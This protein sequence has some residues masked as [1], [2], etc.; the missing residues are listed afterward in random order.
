MATV[1]E[2]EVNLGQTVDDRVSQLL[3]Y[4]EYTV[5]LPDG[6]VLSQDRPK[7]TQMKY[8]RLS[9]EVAAEV[10]RITN[11][12]PN[13]VYNVRISRNIPEDSVR[14]GGDWVIQRD[15][16]QAITCA[17]AG[18]TERNAWLDCTLV[19]LKNTTF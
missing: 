16:R 2:I 14:F 9:Q 17:L 4:R 6:T 1:R 8:D 7:V 19:V 13:N 18:I 5:T 12:I 3:G 11:N 15:G 10:L